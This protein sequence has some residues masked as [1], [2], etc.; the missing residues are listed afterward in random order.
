MQKI[1]SPQI[2]EEA[3]GYERWVLFYDYKWAPSGVNKGA[4][5]FWV[6]RKQ[7]YLNK[8]LIPLPIYE[9]TESDCWELDRWI[10]SHMEKTGENLVGHGWGSVILC[11]KGLIVTA[12]PMLIE[13]GI[14]HL[15]NLV[16]A[17]F[18][19]QI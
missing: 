14:N 19:S 8:K 12:V 17:A 1:D 11:R 15:N 2:L 4:F 6:H 10:L 18:G 13:T 7:I 9:S 5:L 3:Q 16:E